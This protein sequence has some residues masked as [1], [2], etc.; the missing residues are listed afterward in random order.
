MDC[1]TKMK[2]WQVQLNEELRQGQ[3]EADCEEKECAE[4]AVSAEEMQ[5]GGSCKEKGCGG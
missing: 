5:G 3:E 1:I 4:E 2:A